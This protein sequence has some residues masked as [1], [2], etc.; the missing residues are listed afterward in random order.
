MTTLT[1]K[2]KRITNR[3]KKDNV[4][5]KHFGEATDGTGNF[6]E[7]AVKGDFVGK[8]RL[9][10]DFDHGGRG[11]GIGHHALCILYAISVDII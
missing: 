3:K 1:N 10:T 7:V 2:Q 8:P 5:L 6:L 11:C 9:F 4:I